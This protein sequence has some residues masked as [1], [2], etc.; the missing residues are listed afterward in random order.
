MNTDNYSETEAQKLVGTRF[1][2]TTKNAL[3]PRGTQGKVV[4]F[5]KTAAGSYEVIVQ[6][7]VNRA[8]IMQVPIA[9]QHSK[10]DVTSQMEA[11]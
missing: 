4:A 1:R 9:A 11:F 8:F 3:I 10:A 7:E 5:R 2:W 6:W